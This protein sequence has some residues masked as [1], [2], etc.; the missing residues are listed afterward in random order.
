MKQKYVGRG[1]NG[2]EWRWELTQAI[3]SVIMPF[4]RQHESLRI[5]ICCSLAIAVTRM[6]LTLVVT[7]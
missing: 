5:G 6:S 4:V 3:I 2:I 1:A 7:L